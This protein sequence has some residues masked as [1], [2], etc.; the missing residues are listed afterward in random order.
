[1][2]DFFGEMIISALE[3]I[4]EAPVLFAVEISEDSILVGKSSVISGIY[5][6]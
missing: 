3:G 2:H 6:G 5:K 4:L 1:V